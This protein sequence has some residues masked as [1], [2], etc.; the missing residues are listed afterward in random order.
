MTYPIVVS[1]GSQPPQR[2]RSPGS[3]PGEALAN[4]K[5][6]LHIFLE[7]SNMDGNFEVIYLLNGRKRYALVFADNSRECLKA[8][9]QKIGE[10]LYN[11]ILIK[12]ITSL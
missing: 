6:N 4:F 2:Y 9:K 5:N 12:T 7:Q 1:I 11:K 10:E 8:L 3:T